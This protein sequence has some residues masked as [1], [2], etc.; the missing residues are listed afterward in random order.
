[1]DFSS[2]VLIVSEDGAGVAG[3]LLPPRT[4]LGGDPS[5]RPH[6]LLYN[7]AAGLVPCEEAGRSAAQVGDARRS[8][9][10]GPLT[11]V[12]R[13]GMM[14]A[15]ATT[16]SS[17]GGGGRV[18]VRGIERMDGDLREPLGHHSMPAAYA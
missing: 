13:P 9:L 14:G 7:A 1:M 10:A 17:K 5:V 3:W 2:Q 11:N 15:D 16:A 6:V 18:S 8:V 4:R 12:N